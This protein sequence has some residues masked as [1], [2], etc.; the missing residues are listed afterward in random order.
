LARKAKISGIKFGSNRDNGGSVV[1]AE[2]IW[3]SVFLV[4]GIVG[5]GVCLVYIFSREQRH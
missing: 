1:V 5:I 4:M 3:A 2:H